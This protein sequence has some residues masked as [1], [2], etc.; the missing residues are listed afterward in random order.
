MY[1]TN[2]VLLAICDS[3]MTCLHNFVRK[4]CAL[5]R[6]LVY[7]VSTLKVLLAINKYLSQYLIFKQEWLIYIYM[8][9]LPVLRVC[10]CLD[11]LAY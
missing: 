2:N 11:C 4:L 8:K 5:D 7:F 1:N 10:D 6:A 9:Y 3:L